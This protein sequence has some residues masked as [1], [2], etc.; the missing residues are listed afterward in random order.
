M[1]RYLILAVLVL[2]LFVFC[3]QDDYVK[4]RR[5]MVDRQI[6]ARGI[7]D[8]GTLKAMY[9]VPRHLFVPDHMKPY[10]Y[11]DR[12]L[13][14]GNSQTISQPYI[15]GFMTSAIEPGRNDK[16]LEIGTGS[17]YQ[18]A[19]LAEIVEDVYTIEIIPELAAKAKRLFYELNYKNI[20][21][22]TGDGYAGWPSEAP[23]DAIIVTAAPEEIPQPLIDQL[24]DGGKMIIPVG[25][26]T[27]VQSLKLVTKKNGKIK[28]R[29]LLPVRFV[30]FTGEGA[31]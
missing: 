29:N 31:N 14:I 21:P 22:M 9:K 3:S 1:K 8:P 28:E 27:R 16:V 17:G 30:P 2:P 26:V 5:Q 10:A 20:H 13:P 24:K 19:V 23:F 15:V 18:A 7:D 6:K 11:D 25:A 12:P 4:Q